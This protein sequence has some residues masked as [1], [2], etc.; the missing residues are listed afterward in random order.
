MSSTQLFLQ[1]AQKA[2]VLPSHEWQSQFL[3][4]MQDLFSQKRHGHVGAWQ[5]SDSEHKDD[6]VRG[7]FLWQAFVK[8]SNDYYIISTEQ[9][10]ISKA[11]G[12]LLG[13]TG[14]PTTLVDFGPGSEKAVRTKTIPIKSHLENVVAYCPIDLSDTFLEEASRVVRVDQPNISI[15][16]YHADYMHDEITLPDHQGRKVGIYVGGTIAN[17]EGHPNNV[18]PDDKVISLLERFRHILG[19][20][21]ELIMAYDANQDEVS[22]VASYSHP[23]QREFGRNIMHRVKRDLPVIGNF[24]ADAWIYE[25]VWHAKTHQLCHTVIAQKDMDFYLGRERF[26]ILRGESFILNNSFK[27]SVEQMQEWAEKAGWSQQ[28]IVMDD[29]KR[30]A[31]HHLQA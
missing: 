27:Y 20:N 21:A 1:K 24:D 14:M 13:H 29:Q 18:M 17:V 4:D 6:P 31:L 25:P 26:I 3:R 10:L 15:V 7:A 30:V 8:A 9:E 22:I 5:Y 11:S 23:L 12:S 16:P 19:D 28:K 2:D